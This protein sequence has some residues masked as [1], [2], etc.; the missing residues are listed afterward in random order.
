MDIW[1]FFAFQQLS[2]FLGRSEEKSISVLT[3][4]PQKSLEQDALTQ[5]GIFFFKWTMVCYWYSDTL[6]TDYCR[7][8]LTTIHP[9]IHCQPVRQQKVT[10]TPHCARCTAEISSQ[11]GFNLVS[12]CCHL[13][14]LSLSLLFMMM[15]L[16]LNP[17]SRRSLHETKPNISYHFKYLRELRFKVKVGGSTDTLWLEVN[18]PINSHRH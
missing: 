4:A 18:I 14:N 2:A 10:K 17:L 3:Q 9:F 16:P 7:T 13:A 15:I 8:H 6:F 12:D 1:P 5:S 11:T